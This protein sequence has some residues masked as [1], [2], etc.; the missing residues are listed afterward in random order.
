MWYNPWRSPQQSIYQPSFRSR[1]K[2]SFRITA[3]GPFLNL[4]LMKAF[5]LM[6]RLIKR[7]GGRSSTFQWPFT[8]WAWKMRPTCRCCRLGGHR[9]PKALMLPFNAR[10]FFIF[11]PPRSVFI[12]KDTRVCVFLFFLSLSG[13]VIYVDFLD[14]AK[15]I[16]L[17]RVYT[18][19]VML[20][21]PLRGGIYML[22][23]IRA[24]L[25]GQYKQDFR[26]F[27]CKRTNL[28]RFLYLS[29]V[30]IYLVLLRNIHFL[31]C[32]S[33]YPPVLSP[34]Y[35]TGSYTWFFVI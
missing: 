24:V 5:T 34:V 13:L 35:Y 30:F 22:F 32:I 14:V 17:S 3:W 26:V 31:L 8:V 28:E 33:S 18:E 11:R 10:F 16:D 12:N 9:S 23:P 15:P 4:R 19:W 20:W 25:E 29:F 21:V 6:I 27:Q 1:Y 7:I 2:V